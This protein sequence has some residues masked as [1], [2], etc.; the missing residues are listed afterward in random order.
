MFGTGIGLAHHVQ[1]PLQ[2]H[3]HPVLVTRG[4]RLAHNQVACCIHNGL[5]ATQLSP[6]LEIVTQLLFMLGGTG[7]LAQRLKMLPDRLWL[8]FGDIDHNVSFVLTC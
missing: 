7:N 8:E 6:T 1:M 2:H 4:S 5:Q 3:A